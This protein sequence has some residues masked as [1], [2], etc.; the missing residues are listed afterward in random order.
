MSRMKTFLLYVLGILGFMFLSYVLEDGLIENM[1]VKMDGNIDS[2]NYDISIDNVTGKASNVNGIMQFDIINN[3]NEQSNCYAKIDLYS[4]QGLLA[5]TKYIPITD[6]KPGNK[7]TYQIK[8]KGSEIKDYKISIVN[9]APNM[10]SVI[11]IFGWEI[12]LSDVFG[13]DL[14]DLK[15]FGVKL[16]D[17]FSID[18]A[19]TAVE[20]VW[21][22]SINLAKSIPWWGY[23]IA[24]GI[25]VW[26]L[27]SGFLFGIF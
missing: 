1:Y 20:N 27:P 12:D 5:T 25:V 3:S 21:S 26:Y 10:E 22:W 7:K 11:S 4:K 8:F 13:M 18:N 14:S 6:L 9:E 16:T 2:A 17:L 24:T 15:I 19:K 23:A